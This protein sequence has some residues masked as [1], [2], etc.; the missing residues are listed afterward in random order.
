[1]AKRIPPK[2]HD[3]VI[4]GY[5]DGDPEIAII[6]C[7]NGING[8]SKASFS[9]RCSYEGYFPYRNLR[10]TWSFEGDQILKV[11]G[12]PKFMDTNGMN[13]VFSLMKH[14]GFRMPE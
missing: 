5:I 13:M 8:S 1:M 10:S 14:K 7:I 4:I 3:A 9:A 11:L 6:T 12:R 2:V